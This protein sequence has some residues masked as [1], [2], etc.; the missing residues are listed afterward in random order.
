M[1]TL[2]ALLALSLNLFGLDT[3]I[4]TGCLIPEDSHYRRIYGKAMW[5]LQFELATCFEEE[6]DA[7]ANLTYHS[8]NG[9]FTLFKETTSTIDWALNVGIKHYFCSSGP[10]IPY[11][12]MGLG[13]AWVRF[14]DNSLHVRHQIDQWGF[15]FLV[16]SG[17]EWNLCYDYFLD[18]FLD[19]A[20]EHFHGPNR[21][22]GIGT[23]S[24]NT[25]GIKVGLGLGYHW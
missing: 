1:K 5:D 22:K 19:Y 4:R 24:I 15:A 3:E 14:N 6:W 13:A 21:K 10:L 12:G 16:K 8:R 23:R 7:F 9:H 18:F 2:I 11:L 20:Y 17:I 25:G